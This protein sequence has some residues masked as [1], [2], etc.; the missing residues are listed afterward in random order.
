MLENYPLISYGGVNMVDITRR[1]VIHEEIKDQDTLF[2]SYIVKDG[3]L[4]EDVAFNFYGDSNLNMIILLIN[5]IVDPF[6]GWVL[7]S[8]EFEAY[9][10]DKYGVDKVRDIHHHE[11]KGDI[12]HS[13]V[14]GATPVTNY[15]H[16]FKLNEKK[17][18][19]KILKPEYISTFLDE[20]NRSINA[21][22]G[23]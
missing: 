7:S 23:I 18:R 21:E 10:R 11:L 9:V 15:D 12:V 5:S 8:K 20:Y 16:E 2:R 6:Y 19:V 22:I 3:E 14:V 13:T 17:R 1:I 4:P